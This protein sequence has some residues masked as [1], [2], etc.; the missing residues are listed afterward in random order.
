M[1][2]M[3]LRLKRAAIGLL[4]A[5]LAASCGSNVSGQAPPAAPLSPDALREWLT[6]ISSDEFE[7]RATFSP[8]LDKAAEYI[9]ARLKDAGVRPGGDDG[10]Y[11]Q[12]VPVQNVQ[13]VNHSTLTVEANGET[14]VFRNGEG[15]SFPANVGVKRTFVLTDAEFVGY[16]LNMGSVYNDYAGREVKD[17]AVIWLGEAPPSSLDS[18]PGTLRMIESRPSTALEEMGAA[19]SLSVSRSFRGR[20]GN[21]LGFTTT[22]RLDLPRPPE[23]TVADDVLAFIFSASGLNYE[24]LKRKADSGEALT[25][26]TVKGCLLYTSPSPRDS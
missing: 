6:V 7:G 26:A 19:A 24:E 20:F 2:Q 16:G 22:Q 25:P 10:S 13:S 23:I 5:V 14:R 11:L 1:E 9:S 21:A 15:V 17:K 4:I 12:K 18:V 8:G 3:G